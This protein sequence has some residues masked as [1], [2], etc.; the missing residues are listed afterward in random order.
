MHES[1]TEFV[2]SSALRVVLR[3]HQHTH[4]DKYHSM[5]TRLK[6]YETRTRLFLKYYLIQFKVKLYWI[7]EHSELVCPTI[8]PSIYMNI[9]IQG[10]P[11]IL[12]SFWNYTFFLITSTQRKRCAS[13][14]WPI[15]L[16][17][18]WSS[19][20]NVWPTWIRNRNVWA[21]IKIWIVS[22]LRLLSSVTST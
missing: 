11:L 1:Q 10:L 12:H 19:V 21:A 8:H 6:V 4:N 15:C 22:G 7:T 14:L 3:L 13:S 17:L 18:L 2:I 5:Q 20:S 16:L 9:S